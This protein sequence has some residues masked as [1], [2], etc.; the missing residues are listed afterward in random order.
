MATKIPP[1]SRVTGFSH[2][3]VPFRSRLT[4]LAGLVTLGAC[5]SETVTI[6]P[7]EAPRVELP[8]M[9]P[10]LGSNSEVAREHRKL[11]A[12]F[13][14]EYRAP[15]AQALLNQIAE[16]LR[17]VSDRPNE[18][19]RVTILNSPTV[20]AFALPNGYVYL[21]RG[22]LA[23]AN[24]TA[25]VASVIAHE[26][27][28]VTSRHAM[29]R[30]EFQNRSVLVSRVQT[31]ILENAQAGQLMRDQSRVA[32]ASFSR[33]QELEADESGVRA[34][35]KAGFE[36]HG[37]S[38][39][40]VALDRS[41]QMRE[42]VSGRAKPGTDILSTHPTTPERI[43][44]VILIARQYGSPGIGE[45]SRAS[46]L[47][48]INGIVFGEDPAQGVIR[49]GKLLHP[50]LKFAIDAPKDFV[51]EKTSQAVLGVTAGARQAMRLDSSPDG[52]DR[53]LKALLAENPIEGIAITE[54]A[55]ETIGGHPAA[56]GLARGTDWV[57]RVFL[58]RVGGTIYRLIYASQDFSPAVDT[59]FF[60]SARSFRPLSDAEVQE[61]RPQRI[62][63]V[64]AEPGERSVDLAHRSMANLEKAHE[65]FL[66][67]NGLDINDPLVPGQAYKALVSR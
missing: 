59:D 13:G 40:L 62:A 10:T 53:P 48:A 56:T 24:D 5:V 64:K 19:Y 33:Q 20:N 34:I 39:F 9:A 21:T 37:A 35:A 51:L 11:V 66:V 32:L 65:M 61:I 6:P 54:L 67:L 3:R 44:K 42:D 52:A 55:E 58:V 22:L 46:W 26:I 17:L 8:G 31:E 14:G 60:A 49:D 30:A 18:G 15:Q 16:R 12:G 41:A 38:R 50:R 63:L 4:C 57:F 2:P 7:V 36:A 25:E 45:A 28:H 43:N 1:M 27:A 29:E 23:L 47:Q